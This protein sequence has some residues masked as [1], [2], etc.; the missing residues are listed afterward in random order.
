[1]RRKS[2][3]STT[4]V[5]SPVGVSVLTGHKNDRIIITIPDGLEGAEREKFI[6]DKVTA[7]NEKLARKVE[8][9]NPRKK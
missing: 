1:M 7:Y 6:K 4:K 3:I 9:F 5:V 2:S 8:T